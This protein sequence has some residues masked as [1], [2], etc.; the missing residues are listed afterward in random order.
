MKPSYSPY[1]NAKRNAGRTVSKRRPARSPRHNIRKLEQRPPFTPIDW[2]DSLTRRKTNLCPINLESCAE[3]VKHA[4]FFSALPFDIR[5]HIYSVFLQD[6]GY[7]QNIFCPSV[8]RQRMPSE[9]HPQHLLSWR[10]DDDSFE[11]VSACG[12]YECE[13]ANGRA[14]PGRVGTYTLGDLS[15]LMQ[16]CKFAYQ[17]ISAHLYSSLTF[18]FS[19][20]AS[21][22][23]FLDW[24][25]PS[26]LPFV[27]SVAFIAHMLPESSAHSMRLI[28]GQFFKSRAPPPV[29]K[30]RQEATILQE[31]LGIARVEGET[32]ACWRAGSAANTGDPEYDHMGLFLRLPNLQVLE[33]SFFPSRSLWYSTKLREMVA[34]LE[35]VVQRSR[36]RAAAA[37]AAAEAKGKG[38]HGQE[39]PW[40]GEVDGV[41]LKVRVPR[42]LF[43]QP[44]AS[45]SRVRRTRTRREGL[46]L[47]GQLEREAGGW[48]ELIRPVVRAA[49]EGCCS[50]R[51]MRE[52]GPWG[53]KAY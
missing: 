24:I 14:K 6:A 38:K 39:E 53:C 37:A 41:K 31:P 42:L 7:R 32:D 29:P 28:D 13:S 48:Y 30:D 51:M 36:A 40:L 17:E 16:T 22:S 19:S 2:P 50:G 45:G 4:S 25:N 9:L 8:A 10:C 23:A 52:N 18:T 21:L 12:H 15:S 44:D 27:R 20:F 35:E 33:V 1:P 5:H 34:P 46:P 11:R 49:E 43:S 47:A 3:S 26:L